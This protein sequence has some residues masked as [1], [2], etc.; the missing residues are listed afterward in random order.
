MPRLPLLPA[1]GRPLASPR[2]RRHPDRLRAQWRAA[3]AARVGG[4]LSMDTASNAY[5]SRPIEDVARELGSG[6]AGLDPEEA[7]RRLVD[8]GP[9]ALAAERALSSLRLLYEQIKSPLILILAFAAVVSIVA[10]E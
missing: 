10:G 3:R 9:N 4:V 1:P 5:W 6:T 8:V 2:G 7:A